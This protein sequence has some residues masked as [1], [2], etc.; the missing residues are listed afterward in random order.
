MHKKHT[1]KR[2]KNATNHVGKDLGKSHLFSVHHTCIK[3]PNTQEH[4]W[5]DIMT[6]SSV[7]MCDNSPRIII[8]T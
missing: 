8:T 4:I 6:F 3:F 2:I 5:L 1:I 7:M